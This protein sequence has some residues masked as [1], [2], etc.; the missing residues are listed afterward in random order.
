[1]VI[2]FMKQMV[3]AAQ[4]KEIDRCSIE[5]FGMPGIVLM[6]RAALS[7][8]MRIRERIGL[9]TKL[10]AVCGTGNNGG[11]GMAAARILCEN[12]YFCSVYL[13]GTEEKLTPSAKIQWNLIKQSGIP[14]E[15]TFEPEEGTVVIDALFGIGL[16]R[17]ITGK[18]KELI[19]RMND[20]TCFSIDLPS[21]MDADTGKPCG[22][23]VRAAMTVTFGV[24]KLGLALSTGRQYAGDVFVEKIGFPKAVVQEVCEER[25]VFYFERSDIKNMLPKRPVDAYKGSCGK[26]LLVAGSENMIGAARFAG[27]AAYRMGAGLVQVITSKSSISALAS[28]LPAAVFIS[29]EELLFSGVS[30]HASANVEAEEKKIHS[31]ISRIEDVFQGADCVALGPGLG[32]SRQAECLTGVFLDLCS[33]G[34]KPLVLDADGLNHLSR[35]KEWM[36]MLK[37]H[38]VLTPHLGEMSRLTEKSVDELKENLVGNAVSFAQQWGNVSIVLKDSRSVITDGREIYVNLS[39]NSGMAVGGSGDVLTGILGGIFSETA[40]SG[41]NDLKA[42]VQTA[43]FGA[44]LHGR[45]GDRAVEEKSPYSLMPEDILNGLCREF[46]EVG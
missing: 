45:A 30:D 34:N 14:M 29:A 7:F 10:L 32:S 16:S 37:S 28:M 5:E 23:C 41:E 27:E 17:E 43:A 18:Y 22:I 40:A 8:V 36:P 33:R 24:M 15:T 4:A 6:E 3:T 38:M 42:M 12:G 21:G 11:D 46:S 9:D 20:F 39:G 19:E 25:P 26:L 13:A 44:Y 1:M 31:I 35:H 2:I